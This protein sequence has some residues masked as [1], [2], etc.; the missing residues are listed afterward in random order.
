MFYYSS[1]KQ[2]Y[3]TTIKKSHKTPL[4]SY[5]IQV[6]IN[7]HHQIQIQLH[8]YK[9]SH[10]I[11]IKMALLFGEKGHAPAITLAPPFK[12]SLPLGSANQITQPL[13][14]R[15][16]LYVILSSGHNKPF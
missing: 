8:V 15:H 3:M 14:S 12:V 16:Q 5:Q 6:Q 1:F 4:A 10:V 9:C 11:L 7:S 2:S 13:P